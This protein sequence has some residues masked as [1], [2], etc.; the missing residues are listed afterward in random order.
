MSDF[1]I[2]KNTL[3]Y[4]QP[5]SVIHIPTGN[6]LGQYKNNEKAQEAIAVFKKQGINGIDSETP[7]KP[8]N[9]L[10]TMRKRM[11][12]PDGDKPIQP[13]QKCKPIHRRIE[14]KT[15]YD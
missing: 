5:Y 3:P 15:K 11:L 12:R 14:L 8:E 2:R 7:S 6:V 4:I 10:E 9:A 1:A 13:Q